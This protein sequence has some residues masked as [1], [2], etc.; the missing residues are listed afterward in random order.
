[1]RCEVKKEIDTYKMKELFDVF[2]SAML[3]AWYLSGIAIASCLWFFPLPST[4]VQT[5]AFFGMFIFYTL[6]SVCISKLEAIRN[7]LK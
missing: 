4:S 5:F 2:K 6:I 3:W 1:M 7:E